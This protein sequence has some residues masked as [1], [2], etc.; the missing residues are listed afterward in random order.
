MSHR[1]LRGEPKME[2]LV[3]VIF[4][5]Y[6]AVPAACV[7][8]PGIK[9]ATQQCPELLQWQCWI[10]NPMHHKGTPHESD[11]MRECAAGTNLLGG[12]CS[13]IRWEKKTGKNVDPATLAWFMGLWTTH[14]SIEWFHI[15]ARRLALCTALSVSCWLWDATRIGRVTSRDQGDLASWDLF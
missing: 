5:S 1:F 8:R 7:P 3:K 15:G 10:L 9:P 13:K 11:L 2:S 14:C 6:L 4:F 12:V